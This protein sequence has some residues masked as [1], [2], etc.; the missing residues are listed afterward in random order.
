MK[1]GALVIALV[2]SIGINLGLA[3]RFLAPEPAPAVVGAEGL[4]GGGSK[5]PLAEERPGEAEGV[6][7]VQGLTS[8]VGDRT[9][10]GARPFGL[11]QMA[12]E[13]G[14]EGE[15]RQAFVDLKRDFF[16]RT[17]NQR[18]RVAELQTELRAALAV[19]PPDRDGF[20][21]L[22]DRLGEAHGA[23][24]GLFAEHFLATLELLEPEQRPLYRERVLEQLGRGAP[25]RGM[26]AFSEE[27]QRRREERVRRRGEDPR[28]RPGAGERPP[29]ADGSR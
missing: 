13:L 24:E 19:D 12:D 8:D 11:L 28:R 9:G 3:F 7:S 16:E 21:G 4:P 15:P 5:A 26:P 18:R 29:A 25:N 10:P 20:A 23:L 6:G 17:R 1:R 14:L 22:V 27:R 2:F